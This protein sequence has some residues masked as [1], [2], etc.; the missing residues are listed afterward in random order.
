MHYL[1]FRSMDVGGEELLYV[2]FSGNCPTR[3]FVIEF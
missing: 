1:L 3:I 2:F